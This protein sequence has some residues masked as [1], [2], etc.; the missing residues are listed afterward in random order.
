MQE[1]SMYNVVD[2]RT[3]RVLQSSPYTPK[4]FQEAS[5]FAIV[6]TQSFGSAVLLRRVHRLTCEETTIVRITGE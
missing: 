2:A 4:G 1:Y 5:T 6:L 3:M